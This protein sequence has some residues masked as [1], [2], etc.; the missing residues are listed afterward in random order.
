MNVSRQTSRRAFTLIE[1][2]VVIAI[3]A[4]LMGILLPAINSSF[5]SAKRSKATQEAKQIADAVEMF[6]NEYRY[7]PV[8]RA[9]QGYRPGPGGGDFGDE[10]TQPFTAEESRLILQ[11]L[12]AI[13]ENYNDDHDLN[14]NKIPFL[15]SPDAQNDGTFLDPWG[16]QYRI[17]LDRD[18]NGKVEYYSDPDQ[19]QTRVVVV[20]A[21]EDGWGGEEGDTPVSPKDLV[22]N[23]QLEPDRLED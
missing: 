3:V 16:H 4:L 6:Y 12:M 13:P 18:F 10:Q 15:N 19:Y 9:D 14:P 1:L 20:S 23:V 5:R 22:A 11:T 2:L 21:G 7:L 17:K 8:P